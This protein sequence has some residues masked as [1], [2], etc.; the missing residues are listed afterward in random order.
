MPELP[1]LLYI[2]KYL[3]K[4]VCHRTITSVEVKQ[5]IVLR[6]AVDAKF[7]EAL[8]GNRINACELHGSFIRFE[9]SENLDLIMNLMLAGKLQHQKPKEK[10]KGCLCFSLFLNDNSKLNLCDE[11]K[12]AKA[13]LAKHGE[14]E[15][16]PK[17][18]EQ[19]IDILSPEFTLQAF[20]ELASK[21]SRK[22]VRVF[23]N[24]HTILSSI[25]NAYADEILFDAKIHPKTFVNKLSPQEIEQLYRSILSVMK[26]G[27][28]QIEAA[29]QPIHVKVREHM[30][31]RYR[32]DQP[33]PR[34]GAKIRREG[35]RGFDVFFCPT[36]QSATRKG[37][38]DWRQ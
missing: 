33:C 12:M 38:I 29:A 34:C 11:Q 16:I 35:V 30:K 24:D 22:Q 26:W 31:V 19:G 17:Y 3:R 1:D 23:I 15:A 14:Y 36:C 32:K 28:E 18:R 20:R 2:Q 27:I 10:P 4:E 6:V 13:Y 25:G 8:Q 9:F 7:E 37:F 21:H 5:P